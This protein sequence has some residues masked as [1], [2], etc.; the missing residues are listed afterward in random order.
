MVVALSTWVM[1]DVVEGQKHY[2][3]IT[4]CKRFLTS[5]KIRKTYSALLKCLGSRRGGGGGG[6]GIGVSVSAVSVAIFGFEQTNI[7]IN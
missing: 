1:T 7:T 4:N 5:A 6:D 3:I 2:C